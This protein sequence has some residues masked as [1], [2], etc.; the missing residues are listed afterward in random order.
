MFSQHS[1]GLMCLSRAVKDTGCL[2]KTFRL[3][4]A[5]FQAS[6]CNGKASDCSDWYLAEFEDPHAGYVCT[7][8]IRRNISKPRRS[9]SVV[10]CQGSLSTTHCYDY[11]DATVPL[12]LSNGFSDKTERP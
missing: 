8:K 11:D 3:V 4:I 10:H 12:S 9:R 5:N 7:Q 6:N 1:R 2:M